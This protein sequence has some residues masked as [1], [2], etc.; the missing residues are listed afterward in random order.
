MDK[1]RPGLVATYGKT[2][3]WSFWPTKKKT[4]KIIIYV[5]GRESQEVK[6]YRLWYLAKF[7]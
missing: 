2:D 6:M 1:T 3:F 5:L 7:Q 4:N